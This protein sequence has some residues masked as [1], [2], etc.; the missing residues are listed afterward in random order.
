MGLFDRNYMTPDAQAEA[1]KAYLGA[2]DGVDGSYDKE[3]HEYAPVSIG[4][5]HNCRERGYVVMFRNKQTKQLNIAFFEHRNSDEI[6]AIAWEQ[7]TINPPTIET[8]KFGN[9]YKD[10]YDVSHSVGYGNAA[11][12]AAWIMERLEAHWAS[13]ARENKQ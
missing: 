7:S 4:Q 8:A 2:Y 1:V 13:G 11:D 10:K 5:W 3:V 12:M 9:V 6:C